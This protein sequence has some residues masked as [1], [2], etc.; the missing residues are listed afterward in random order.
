MI[1]WRPSRRAVNPDASGRL[2]ILTARSPLC[3]KIHRLAFER[4]VEGEHGM[5]ISQSKECRSN[6]QDA[7][8]RRHSDPHRP[9]R[10]R[11]R[12]RPFHFH[13]VD[14]VERLAANAKIAFALDGQAMT[15]PRSRLR[16]SPRPKS[17][18]PGH[19]P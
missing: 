4:H 15:W 12:R 8:Q 13:P 3:Q 17:P 6:D 16:N 14:L 1:V 9:T 11:T 5:G 19:L 2:P 10:I 7:E 18:P